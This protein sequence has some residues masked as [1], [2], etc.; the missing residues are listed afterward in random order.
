MRIRAFLDVTPEGAR[1]VP[2]AKADL[3][4]VLSSF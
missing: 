1:Q 4:N 3:L 2:M